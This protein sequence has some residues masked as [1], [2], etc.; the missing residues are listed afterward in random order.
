MRLED[1]DQPLVLGA[2]LFQRFQLVAAGTERAGRCVAQRGDCLCTFL[3]GVDQDFGQRTEDAVAS[4]IDLAD[5]HF[6]LSRG[7][8]NAAGGGVDDGGDA[9]GLGI[10]GILDGCA[11][12]RHEGIRSDDWRTSGAA[13]ITE[14]LPL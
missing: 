12:F 2:V 8:D 10:E 13:M 11:G 4:G 9:A 7:F 6:V 3:R 14:A 5:F 1:F